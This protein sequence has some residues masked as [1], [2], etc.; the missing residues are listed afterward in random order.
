[1]WPTEPA[2]AGWSFNKWQKT[3]IPKYRHQHLNSP[4]RNDRGLA[5]AL[6]VGAAP[7]DVAVA[8]VAEVGRVPVAGVALRADRVVAPA[9]RAR[10]AHAAVGAARAKV[11]TAK[12]DAA[13]VEASS[14]RT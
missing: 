14:S 10:A 9:A 7:A 1:V 2:R 13:T 6:A 3:R 8:V 11:V 4:H 12:A 5:A